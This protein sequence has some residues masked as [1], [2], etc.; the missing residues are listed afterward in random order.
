MGGRRFGI[1]QS[2]SVERRRRDRR[3]RAGGRRSGARGDRRRQSRSSGV[4]RGLDPGAIEPPRSCR[5]RNP[6]AQGRARQAPVARGRQDAARGRGRGDAGR[7]HLQVLR[8]RSAAPRGRKAAVGASRHRRRGD[9]RA[10]RRRRPHHA[11][12]FSDRDSGVEN[13]ARARVRQHGRVQARGPRAR[14]R[15]GARRNPGEGGR[16]GGCVQPGDGTRLDRRRSARE[17]SGCRRDQLHRLGRNGPRH[18]CQGRRANGQGPAR[19]GRQESARRAGRRRSAHCRKR[20][21]AGRLSS[22]PASAARHRRG[23]S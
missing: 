4:G 12:E 20:R 2:Q 14:M 18:R 3:V 10:D 23:S 13:R 1:A 17:R 9:A 19:N 15:L 21:D 7:A 16:S 22:R 11:V 5:H 6:R 8:R